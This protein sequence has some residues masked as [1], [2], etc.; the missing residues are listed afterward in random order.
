MPASPAPKKATV[1]GWLV[2]A[3]LLAGITWGLISSIPLRWIV[4]G[5]FVLIAALTVQLNF[6]LSRIRKERKE[7]SICTFARALPARAH[8]TWIVRAVY[9]ELSSIIRAPLRPTD[10]IE[11]LWGIV[12]EDLDDVASRVAHRAGRSMDDTRK[13][14]MFGRVV[15]VAD[16]VLFFEHQAK[17]PNQPLQR[18]D[19]SCHASCS[20]TPRASRG[21][22]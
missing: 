1:T 10:N 16:M 20:R 3:V 7:E 18:N 22:G 19:P 11:K 21:R 17:L 4:A 5:A 2:L 14:P 6:Q 12:D 13:N 8:D 15:T 9:E